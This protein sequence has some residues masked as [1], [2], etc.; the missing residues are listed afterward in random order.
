ME[1]QDTISQSEQRALR[2]SEAEAD[3]SA[4]DLHEFAQDEEAQALCRLL[5]EV[6]ATALS[7]PNPEEELAVFHRRHTYRKPLIA[8]TALLTAAAIALFVWLL[9]PTT[10]VEP[11]P[12]ASEITLI[13]A[14][15]GQKKAMLQI[16]ATHQDIPLYSN[17]GSPAATIASM[18]ARQL[19]YRPI[20]LGGSLPADADIATHRV[21]IPRGET[22]QLT[23]SDGTQVWLNTDSRITYPEVFT[24]AERIVYLEG[25]AY[26]KVAAD[27]QHPF[28]VRTQTMET[29]VLG[30]EFNF[31]SYADEPAQVALVKGLVEVSLPGTSTKTSIHPGQS[32]AVGKS[33]KIHVNHVDVDAYTYWRE[34]LFYFD[35]CSLPYILKEI[36]RWYN[37]DVEL[38]SK[39]LATLNLH[40]VADRHK[41]L[42]YTIRLLN[43]MEQMEAHLVGGRLIV[44]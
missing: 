12:A 23:L 14:T 30:T 6:D 35:N 3:I 36:G 33:G 28:I 37:V 26:F 39:R 18:T 22:Y 19:V 25:E 17:M 9:R 24:K 20:P 42:V 40:F 7:V 38:R 15:T 5:S 13:K 43:Q 10:T 31:R 1:N 44:E 29:R 4:S 21:V 41:P 2:M 34:G 8:L 32:A 16:P 11:Q 27:S